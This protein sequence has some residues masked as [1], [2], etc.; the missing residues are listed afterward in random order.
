MTNVLLTVFI[1]VITKQPIL[2][3]DVAGVLGAK[4]PV[5]TCNEC[6]QVQEFGKTTPSLGAG[7][8]PQPMT[9]GIR[10]PFEPCM[11]QVVLML[12]PRLPTPAGGEVVDFF[13][14]LQPPGACATPCKP[15]M[16]QGLPSVLTQRPA[17]DAGGAAGGG[18]L[19]PEATAL[20]ALGRQDPP[21][22]PPLRTPR[23][24]RLLRHIL[25]LQTHLLLAACPACQPE[26]ACTSMPGGMQLGRRACDMSFISC[27]EV[28]KQPDLAS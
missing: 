11:A 8:P 21:R 22:H 5:D 2:F 17:L 26:R 15:C 25:L 1:S 14:G 3:S 28:R 27:H 18:G 12:T 13:L 23:C 7:H 24:A 4:V 20:P 16:E 6:P 9:W 10:N 19:L